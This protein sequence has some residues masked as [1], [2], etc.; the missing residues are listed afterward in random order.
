MAQTVASHAVAA[1][2]SPV[3]GDPL[4]ATV[5]LSND[6]TVRA[7]YVD[8][9]ADPGIHLQ[10]SALASRPAFGT[11][12]RKWLSADTGSYRLFFDTGSA[13]QELSY[14]RTDVAGTF[15]QTLTVSGSL[16]ST[17]GIQASGTVAHSIVT[18]NASGITLTS[19]VGT[20]KV[21][22][23]GSGTVSPVYGTTITDASG[24]W[25]ALFQS[26]VATS[27]GIAISTSGGNLCFIGVNSGGEITI[28]DTSGSVYNSASDAWIRFSPSGSSFRYPMAVN[29]ATL[30]ASTALLTTAGTTSVSSLRIPHGAAPTSPV[31]GDMWTTTAGLFIRI[32]G[33][34][35]GP[36]S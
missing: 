32:N 7:A 24:R 25:P 22:G 6:N 27:A 17:G 18:S 19:S 36:L 13:W 20:T 28:G 4:S 11:A 3:N 2:T 33:S 35:V 34:T 30:S 15:T 16:V 1:L 29:N 26:S 12:G 5:V 31:N 9:D 14:L 8:H 10:S 21:N 23:V